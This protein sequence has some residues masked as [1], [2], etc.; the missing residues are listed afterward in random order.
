MY[1]LLLFIL[2]APCY[3]NAQ[4]NVL[5]SEINT[6]LFSCSFINAETGWVAGVKVYKTTNGGVNWVLQY[7]VPANDRMDCLMFKNGYS[8]WAGSF[9]GK[10]YKTTNAGVNWEI[11][12]IAANY[13]IRDIYFIDIN[14]GWFVGQDGFYRKTT[15]G[16]ITW[17]SVATIS[18]NTLNSIYFINNNTG[19]T[20]GYQ[21][22]ASTT[23]S[24][25]NWNINS[26]PGLSLHA[27][28]FLNSSTGWVAGNRYIP[29]SE[30]SGLYLLKTQNSGINWNVI[31]ADTTGF[32]QHTAIT[33]SKFLT[34]DIGYLSGY[35]ILA[36]PSTFNVG[37]IKKTTNGGVNWQNVNIGNP[38]DFITDMSFGNI[39]TGYAVCNP[40][41][42]YKT[43]NGGPVGINTITENIPKDFILSQNYPNPF[44]PSTNIEFDVPNTSVV[45]LNLYDVTGRIVEVL[46]NEL[47]S[48]G[49]YSVSWDGTN[50]ASGIYFYTL[51]TESF[52]QT[53]RMVLVK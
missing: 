49:R 10:V 36:G 41:R 33:N 13:N 48:P 27:I 43:T 23:N 15:N 25:I 26:L 32:R 29:A 6:G 11:S 52:T 3:L 16:G 34:S 5:Q 20:C 38:P 21:V 31:C 42:I 39:Q 18:S 4:W 47:V 19:F 24:G 50:H 51:K 1:R 44:N 35:T 2:L 8:G 22:L 30:G 45:S 12:S 53:K 9:Q 37:S 17:L 46:T 7:D 40:S 14:T 28:N